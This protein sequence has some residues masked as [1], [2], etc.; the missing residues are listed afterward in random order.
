MDNDSLK[1]PFMVNKV[2][3]RSKIRKE[4]LDQEKKEKEDRLEYLLKL[5]DEQRINL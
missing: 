2:Y 4:K 5:Q 3:K 1:L